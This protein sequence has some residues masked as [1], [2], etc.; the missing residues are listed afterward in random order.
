MDPL[1]HLG[2]LRRWVSGDVSI[3]FAEHAC[4]GIAVALF[5]HAD[6]G[7]SLP[8]RVAGSILDEFARKHDGAVDTLAAYREWVAPRVAGAVDAAARR[9]T[10]RRRRLSLRVARDSRPFA[11]DDDRERLALRATSSRGLCVAVKH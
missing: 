10:S 3:A 6:L 4:R 1:K 9:R 2:A 8:A 11:R 5:A 7:A